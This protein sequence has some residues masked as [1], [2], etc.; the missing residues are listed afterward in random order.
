MGVEW[1]SERPL[2][3]LDVVCTEVADMKHALRTL[4]YHRGEA[5]GILEDIS[6]RGREIVEH[7]ENAEWSAFRPLLAQEIREIVDRAGS[8]SLPA[9]PENALGEA[10]G[11]LRSAVSNAGGTFQR[12]RRG[13]RLW[14]IHSERTSSNSN[15]KRHRGDAE[16]RRVR[17]GAILNIEGAKARIWV[18]GITT[19]S[20]VSVGIP[21][22]MPKYLVRE[23]ATFDAV[24][25]TTSEDIPDAT[26]QS[27]PVA[28]LQNPDA[29]PP[30]FVP[31]DCAHCCKEG[32]HRPLGRAK[33][34][35]C[36][37]EWCR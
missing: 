14:E 6:V 15:G 22:G 31:C 18:N 21:L 30:I 20:G 36:L 34:C 9:D 8:L 26:F 2:A 13:L 7:M 16:G 11:E 25:I 23:R 4:L 24:G 37:R 28:H 1:P 35:R 10:F 29:Y 17:V 5:D 3:Q 32:G 33:A 12:I 19:D 27:Q